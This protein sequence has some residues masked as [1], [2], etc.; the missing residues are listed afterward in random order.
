MCV[1]V[2]I[3]AADFFSRNYSPGRS[4]FPGHG[5]RKALRQRILRVTQRQERKNTP[6]GCLRCAVAGAAA[7]V[8]GFPPSVDRLLS[9]LTPAGRLNA[10]FLLTPALRSRRSSR[11]RSS[12]VV[13]TLTSSRRASGRRQG[14]ALLF[15]RTVRRRLG[16]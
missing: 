13:E 5:T 6:T 9:V 10:A 11:L 14:T 2:D 1:D 4:A 15:S 3:F 8:R 12:S 16:L 7:V